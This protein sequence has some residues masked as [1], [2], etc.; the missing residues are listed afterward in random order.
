M[1]MRGSGLRCTPRQRCD[2]HHHWLGCCVVHIVLFL[3]L[4]ITILF[5]FEWGVVGAS[6]RKP[7]TWPDVVALACIPHGV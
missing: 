4:L 7:P 2:G 6:L 5:V 3:A 1:T